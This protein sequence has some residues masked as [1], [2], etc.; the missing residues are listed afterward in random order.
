MR[1]LEAGQLSH[2]LQEFG[3]GKIH[4]DDRQR[5]F[6]S[7]ERLLKRTLPTQVIPGFAPD[8]S[9]K[10]EPIV[11]GRGGVRQPR[12]GGAARRPDRAPRSGSASRGSAASRG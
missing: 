4:L 10:A 12:P 3:F 8:P 9:V 5:N 7:I 1:N 11:T 2:G 6:T